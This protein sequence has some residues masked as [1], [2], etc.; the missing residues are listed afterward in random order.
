MFSKI[1]LALALVGANAKLYTENAESQ[2]YMWN[3]FK[4]TFRENVMC[5][6]H[7]LAPRHTVRSDEWHGWSLF[8]E[9]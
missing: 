3:Q 1:V 6:F 8:E 4:V 9:N 5:V 7:C 2:R